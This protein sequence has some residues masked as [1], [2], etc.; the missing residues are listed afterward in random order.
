MGKENFLKINSIF[1]YIEGALGILFTL[2]FVLFPM[3]LSDANS[4][5]GQYASMLASV[6]IVGL[7]FYGGISVGII[8]V[9]RGLWKLKK[10]AGV[11]TSIILGVQILVLL[12]VGL[13]A[14]NSENLL[15]SVLFIASL[16][17]QIVLLIFLILGWGELNSEDSQGQNGFLPKPRKDLLN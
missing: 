10:W 11:V 13:S 1:L 3:F 6:L 7:I 8:F 2:F 15:F 16:V 12:L 4:L 5:L 17:L 14:I 9:G